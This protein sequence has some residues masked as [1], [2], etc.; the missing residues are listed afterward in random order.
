MKPVAIA[1]VVTLALLGCATSRP[2]KGPSGNTAYVIKCGSARIDLCYE[3]AAKVCPTGYIS[4]DRQ[5]NA[6][7]AIVPMGRGFMM[8]RGPNTMLIECKP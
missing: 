7:V 1:L 8:A 6:N 5:D 2:I 3:E 4:A